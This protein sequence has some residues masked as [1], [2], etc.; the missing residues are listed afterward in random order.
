LLAILVGGVIGAVNGAFCVFARV[1]SVLVTLIS[2]ILLR[3]LVMQ[4][5]NRLI[6]AKRIAR[7]E[8]PTFILVWLAVAAITFGIILFT[9]LGKPMLQR[10]KT[11]QRS[12][13][14]FWA[15]VIAGGMA[16]VAGTVMLMR[17]NNF[18][19]QIGIGYEPFLLFVWAF[20]SCSS[21]F[22]RKAAPALVSMAAA[23]L[24]GILQFE[25]SW[26]SEGMVIQKIFLAILCLAL[27]LPAAL[28]WWWHRNPQDAKNRI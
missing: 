27:L 1:P 9:R 6:L 19:P 28:R 26:F 16:G 23:L 24:C 14:C 5:S 13:P 18:D 20:I 12:V 11:E 17:M 25:F 7:L 4:L 22:D 2:G 15:F 8:L 3:Q 21:L 10:T